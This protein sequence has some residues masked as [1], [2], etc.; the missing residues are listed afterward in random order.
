MLFNDKQIDSVSR[1]LDVLQDVTPADKTWWYRGQANVNWRLEPSI[2]RAPNTPAHEVPLMNRFKQN[3][4]S[5]L[6]RA[7]SDAWEWLFLMQHHRVPTR[8]LDWSENPLV[9][10]YF[11]VTDPHQT[12]EDGC[13]WC[14]DP[15]SLNATSKINN[16]AVP[17][18]IPCF[19][20][21][22]ELDAYKPVPIVNRLGPRRPVAALAIRYFPR[23]IAQAGVFTITHI[24][25]T[26]IE[27]L[28][29]GAH[30][31][32]LLIPHEAKPTIIND[33]RLLGINELAL[34]PELDNVARHAIREVIG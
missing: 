3:A 13:L 7:P 16:P 27:E 11:A 25:Q 9:A 6:T 33:L 24:D 20:E 30:V 4:T 10:L 34:F 12:G 28:D 19:S 15:I 5:I 14:M 22:E 21:D 26:P 18:D 31:G 23:L 32:R 8:L 29:A 17:R 2:A 1:L